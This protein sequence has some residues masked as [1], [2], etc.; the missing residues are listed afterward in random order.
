L[1]LWK[2]ACGSYDQVFR[3]PRI[4]QI[5]AA[6]SGGRW[7]NGHKRGGD[8]ASSYWLAI[9]DKYLVGFG[10]GKMNMNQSGAEA[11]Y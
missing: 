1:N 7:P 4:G 5:N 2:G 3:D 10:S 8:E 11:Q 9:V 6:N